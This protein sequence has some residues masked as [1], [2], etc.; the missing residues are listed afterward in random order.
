MN[1]LA[2]GIS[3]LDL[4][5]QGRPRVIASAVLHSAAGVAIVDPGPTTT[6]PQLRLELQTAGL[7]F[8]DIDTLLLTHIHL[9]HAGGTGTI[10]AENPRIRVY[11]HEKGAAHLVAPEKLVSSA[12]RLYGDAMERLWGEI[13]PVPS[14]AILPL[15]GGEQLSAGGRSLRVAYTPGHASHHVSYFNEDS[16]IAFVGDVA[17]VRLL[18]NGYVI[19][20]TPPPDIDLEH[21]KESL[22]RIGAWDPSALFITHFG[23]YA[24][25]RAQ[26]SE[27][28]DRIDWVSQLARRSLLREGSDEERQR[29]FSAH[30]RDQLRRSVSADEVEAYEIAGRFDLNWL[31]LARYWRKRG[32]P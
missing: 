7:S 25:G 6:L 22:G 3:Y 17:G 23:T 16:G 28:A 4:N 27:L 20:P 24:Q 12:L 30:L 1:R 13:R 2:A 32:V 15:T 21:W 8:R 11:V 19:P 10:L 5:F 18:P 14:E 26:L 9:D 31:G 29:W